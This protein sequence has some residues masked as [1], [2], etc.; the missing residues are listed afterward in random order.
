[1]LPAADQVYDHLRSKIGRRALDGGTPIVGL[2]GAQGSG[3][4]TIADSVA[5]RLTL[6]G[7]T[8]ATLSLDDLYLSGPERRKLAAAVHPLLR[9]RGV[10]GTHDV[11]LGERLLSQLSLHGDIALPRFDKV[12]DEPRPV[13]EWPVISC[14]ADM[15]ILDG[16]CVGAV[17]QTE[18]ALIEPVNDLEREQDPQG[19]W[20]RFVNNDLGGR[21]QRL[22]A[23]MDSLI[24]LAA[25][26]FG[27]VA[28]WR[29]EQERGLRASLV[30]GANDASVMDDEAIGVFV[31][32]YARLTQHILA[33]M[34]GRADLTIQLDAHRRPIGSTF[35]R[36][37]HRS[38][39]TT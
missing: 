9:T 30:S 1:M 19:V 20:R 34:P 36:R 12:A 14:P 17:P 18:E 26:N 25:P 2:C 22:F 4:S 31:Q 11:A 39:T 8:V 32:H 35:R 3:K 13:G 16:W 29:R 23:R 15:I 10:P 7:F 24:L 37:A 33:E 28:D 6:E 21:Y 27:V 38:G 5:R